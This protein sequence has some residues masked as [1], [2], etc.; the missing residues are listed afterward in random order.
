MSKNH[1][2]LLGKMTDVIIDIGLNLQR[3]QVYA[4][5]FPTT[6]MLELTADLYEAIVRFLNEIIAHSQ[7]K[8]IS[9]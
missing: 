8:S 9:R 2:D 5:L 4:A 3:V 7:K 6:R 1:C